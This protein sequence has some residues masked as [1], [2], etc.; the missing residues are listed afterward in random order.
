M[1]ISKLLRAVGNAMNL[2]LTAI[3]LFRQLAGFSEYRAPRVDTR[4]WGSTGR[5]RIMAWPIAGGVIEIDF[6][7]FFF[8]L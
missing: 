4:D 3:D 6:F 7:L 5:P 2:T 8:R 1:R